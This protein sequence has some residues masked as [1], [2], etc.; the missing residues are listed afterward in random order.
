M[1]SIDIVISHAIQWDEH[2]TGQHFLYASSVYQGIVLDPRDVIEEV[3][4]A[5]N[6]EYSWVTF[7]EVTPH[8]NSCRGSYYKLDLMHKLFTRHIYIS[9][10]D[11]ATKA[12]MLMLVGSMIF[13]DKNFYT[14]RGIISITFYKHGWMWVIELGS[15]CVGHPLQIYQRCFHVHLQAAQ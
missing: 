8:V 1:A 10:W 6:I 9:I 15:S 14:C 12:Y 2:Y 4:V 13:V 3:V 5:L 7:S 11:C